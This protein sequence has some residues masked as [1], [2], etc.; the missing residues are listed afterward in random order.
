M[1]PNFF[2]MIIVSATALL[3]AGGCGSEDTPDIPEEPG[4]EVFTYNR[5]DSAAFCEIMRKAQADYFDTFLAMRNIRLDS[6]L[7]WAPYVQWVHDSA[8]KEARILYLFIEA[9][10][11]EIFKGE[12]LERILELDSLKYLDIKGLSIGGT[13]PCRKDCK[14]A[15]ERI[16]VYNTSITEIPDEIFQY[17]RLVLM[18]LSKNYKLK[19]PE[20]VRKRKYFNKK[21]PVRFWFMENGFTGTCPLDMPQTVNLEKNEFTAVS[22]EGMKEKDYKE[23]FKM[24]YWPGPFLMNNKITGKLPDYILSDTLATIYVCGMISSQRKGYGIGN[25]PTDEEIQKMKEEYRRNH[26]DEVKDF[27]GF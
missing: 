16:W 19:F 12:I 4:K 9:T 25:K 11:V 1:K 27:I 13:L 6:I 2:A 14:S 18:Q 3:V 24:E 10:N 15:L 17:P 22:W 5:N 7:T 21:N 20:G 26:P 8:T 23:L